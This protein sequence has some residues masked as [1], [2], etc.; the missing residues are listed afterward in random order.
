VFSECQDV[1]HLSCALKDYMSLLKDYMSLLKDYRL[2]LT[3]SYV[4]FHYGEHPV[5]PGNTPVVW[6][7]MERNL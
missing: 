1:P 2:L 7:F 5:F 3:V 4:A 6:I